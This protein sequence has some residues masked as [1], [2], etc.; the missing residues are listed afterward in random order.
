MQKAGSIQSRIIPRTSH[1]LNLVEK[2]P[3]PNLK[4]LPNLC[5]V[6]YRVLNQLSLLSELQIDF[7]LRVL[8]LDV[9]YINRDQD[10]CRF[11]L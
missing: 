3:V 6:L 10:I 4:C 5:C 9:R 11:T 1:T 2:T 8:S 7:F